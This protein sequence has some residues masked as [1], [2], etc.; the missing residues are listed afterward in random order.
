MHEFSSKF[1][2]WTAFLVTALFGLIRGGESLSQDAPVPVPIPIDT[3]AEYFD[4]VESHFDRLI[5]Y[6]TDHYGHTRSGMWVAS[7]DIRSNELLAPEKVERFDKRY[8]PGSQFYW[9]QPL[10]LAAYELGKRSGCK[11][12]P[13]AADMYLRSYLHLAGKAGDLRPNQANFYNVLSDQVETAKVQKRPLAF[14]TPAWEILSTHDPQATR[15]MIDSVVDAQR[16]GAH[17]DAGEAAFAIN[18]LTWMMD[19]VK[20]E[21]TVL[22]KQTLELAETYLQRRLKNQR[23]TPSNMPN[24]SFAVAASMVEAWRRTGNDRFRDIA[25]SY[26][27]IDLETR[28]AHRVKDRD[29][30]AGLGQLDFQV[31][32]ACVTLYEATENEA[33]LNEIEC[34]AE[35]IE[36]SS[37]SVVARHT[38]SQHFGRAIHFLARAS[39]LLERPEY[40]DL[41]YEVGDRAVKQLFVK[42]TGM[43]RSRVGVDRCDATDGPGWLLLALLYL[44]G[45]DATV[46]SALRF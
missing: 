46:N 13:D 15:R 25:E 37:Q 14:H 12:Y 35:A 34:F 10:L 19:H 22:A 17:T 41:A 11:C 7:I 8:L 2:P 18:S 32:E 44:D 36:S 16:R 5:L 24:P 45:D 6:A 33:Y 21:K 23:T 1:R 28:A 27:E 38:Q 20:G 9:D 4:A 40:Y 29:L 43:F 30:R 39:E 26:V 31:A 3:S 42:E